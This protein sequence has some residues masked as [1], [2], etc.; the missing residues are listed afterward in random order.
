MAD[1]EDIHILVSNLPP[2]VVEEDIADALENLGYDLSVSLA[3][4]GSADRVTAVVRFDGMTR[5]TAETLADRINGMPWRDR[6]L[7]A[8]VSLFFK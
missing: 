8:Y 5:R 4:E 3:R 6:I 7:R 1:K 2:D